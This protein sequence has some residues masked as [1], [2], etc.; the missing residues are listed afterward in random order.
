MQTLKHKEQCGSKN[1]LH[2]IKLTLIPVVIVYL[3]LQM[4]IT[5]QT[6]GV[7]FQKR[8]YRSKSIGRQ[9]F[10]EYTTA[11]TFVTKAFNGSNPEDLFLKLTRAAV[12]K[13]SN[14]F[15]STCSSHVRLLR[16]YQ[17]NK[18]GFL[19]L[20]LSTVPREGVFYL[21]KALESFISQMTDE[22]RNECVIVIFL[23]SHNSTWVNMTLSM[24]DT[25]F[26]ESVSTGLIQI[27]QPDPSIYPDFKTITKR[28][29]NDTP[30][31]VHW[32]TKQNI[33]YAYLFAYCEKLSEYYMHIEDDITAA[34]GYINEIRPFIANTNKSKQTWFLLEFSTLG[35]IGKLF[36]SSDMCTMKDYFLLFK[37]EKPCDLL[38]N[39]LK[40][41]KTQIKDF[42]SPK[43]LFQHFGVASSL[44]GK[45]QKLT[46]KN[47]KD[48]PKRPIARGQNYIFPNLTK[49]KEPGDLSI[50]FKRNKFVNPRA[51][52]LTSMETYASFTALRPYAV[53]LGGYYWAKSPNASDYYRILF[54][55][56]INI[57]L[58][59]IKTGHP[60][61]K[62][63]R[64]E[65][66]KVKA[67]HHS[68]GNTCEDDIILGNFKNGIFLTKFNQPL[69]FVKCLDIIVTKSQKSWMIIY[70]IT[71]QTPDMQK[72]INRQ[73]PV[74][75]QKD[76]DAKVKIKGRQIKPANT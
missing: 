31:R 34:K 4:I 24:I 22:N 61:K 47:F 53:R 44:K 36:R 6:A 64:L 76:A 71:V 32:R 9:Y 59:E 60:S 40:R 73:R 11:A 13:K 39:D 63:D 54:D 74:N 19:T 35:F 2:L 48:A 56:P 72:E 52:V 38:I 70:E 26:A 69:L 68:E 50:N 27:I 43:S 58:L 1:V 49:K 15:Q 45:I 5:T 51:R 3:F 25:Q 8:R 75:V 29:Y 65:S 28:N 18:R 12:T 67:G 46:D 37:D 66:A 17:R 30:V 14:T 7:S 16:G 55:L 62:S 10:Q 57:T 41:I 23:G 21:P 42:K 33:D 20:G